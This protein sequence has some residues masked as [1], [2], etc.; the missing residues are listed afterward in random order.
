MKWDIEYPTEFGEWCDILSEDE[1]E[2]IALSVG[3]LEALGAN[4]PHPPSDTIKGPKFSNMK[5]LR[6]LRVIFLDVPTQNTQYRKETKDT[7][8]VFQTRFFQI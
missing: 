3:L 4:L 8:D 5:E 2:S 1:Q 7:T 6:A